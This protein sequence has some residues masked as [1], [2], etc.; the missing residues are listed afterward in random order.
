MINICRRWKW[1]GGTGVEKVRER[2]EEQEEQV[3]TVEI[4]WRG[5][6]EDGVVEWE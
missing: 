1:G 3:M 4:F 2:E 6:W 5:W